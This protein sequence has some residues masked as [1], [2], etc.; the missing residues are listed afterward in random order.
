MRLTRNYSTL[1]KTVGSESTSKRPI[2]VLAG[3]KGPSW[4]WWPASE[5]IEQFYPYSTTKRNSLQNPYR[6]PRNKQVQSMNT[7]VWVV[8][9]SEWANADFC[10]GLWGMK[11]GGGG[12]NPISRANLYKPSLYKTTWRSLTV[13]N[14]IFAFLERTHIIVVDSLFWVYWLGYTYLDFLSTGQPETEVNICKTWSSWSLH[15]KQ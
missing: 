13:G 7:T 3:I 8:T 5:R 4:G 9:Q 14:N 12:E 15:I 10:R 1:P 11:Q 6:T 2:V